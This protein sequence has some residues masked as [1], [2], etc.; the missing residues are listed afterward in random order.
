HAISQHESS[1]MQ[2]AIEKISNIDFIDV[3]GY[4]G[5]NVSALSFAMKGVHPHDIASILD[6]KGICIRAGHHCAH[7]L[8]SFYKVPST[9]RISF[10]M[11]TSK[12]EIDVCIAALEEVY[13][14]F[15]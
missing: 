14:L 3:L 12:H 9:S 13:R 7:P 1:I 11:Y 10:A 4:N 2:Y 6:K 15:S 5:T 8:M